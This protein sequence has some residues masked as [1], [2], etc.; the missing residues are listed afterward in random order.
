MKFD[1]T[2]KN[3]YCSIILTEL[4]SGLTP[5][6]LFAQ[7]SSLTAYSL[8]DVE[9]IK[10]SIS[11]KPLIILGGGFLGVEV[12][13]NLAE[14]RETFDTSSV[15]IIMPENEPLSALFGEEIGKVVRDRLTQFGVEI[16]SGSV[17]I[18]ADKENIWLEN[19]TMVSHKGSIVIN[20]VG[21]FLDEIGYPNILERTELHD[22][23]I[24][25]DDTG[26]TS[27]SDVYAVGDCASFGR[28]QNR[29]HWAFAQETGKIA[30]NHILQNSEE[31]KIRE[32]FVWSAIAGM[33]LRSV[34]NCLRDSDVTDYKFFENG[35][36]KICLFLDQS[37]FVL[38]AVTINA[39]PLCAKL[40]TLFEHQKVPFSDCVGG[41]NLIN[42]NDFL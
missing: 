32:T 13:A 33:N 24:K 39:D 23:K 38:G 11:G 1:L 31:L 37:N 17:P 35:D 22:G 9:T 7:I 34:G 29:P 25:T 40:A 16:I 2:E 10:S 19:G 5:R 3:S 36:V 14:K 20:A 30:A 4:A 26:K 28:Y 42:L 8:A 12:A 15:K 27:I 18:N 41:K 21:T 6:I